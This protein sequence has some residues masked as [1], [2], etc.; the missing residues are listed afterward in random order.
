MLM[1]CPAEPL[2][3]LFVE[4]LARIVPS[5]RWDECLASFAHEKP[6][7]FR[8]NT[9]KATVEEVQEELEQAGFALGP[10]DWLGGAFT[11]EPGE[12][13][14]LTETAAVAEGRIYIQGLS[15]MVAPVVLASQPGE[16]VLDLAAAPG[17]KTLQMAA[18]MHNQGEIAAVEVIRSRMYRLR[19]NLRRHGATIL[20]ANPVHCL[21]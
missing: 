16:R 17:G 12:R 9:L 6:T 15:S 20:I 11:V 4:R 21:G 3:E 19:A 13:R 18:L 14:R 7:A 5:D 1:P 2:P 8:V 10:V